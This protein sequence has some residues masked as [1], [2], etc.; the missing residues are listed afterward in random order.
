MGERP[1]TS[2]ADPESRRAY[3]R[4]HYAQNADAYKA[5]AREK[6][7][8]TRAEVRA[9]VEQYLSD[10]SCIDCGE[11][12]RIVLE[13]DH[14]ERATKRFNIGDAVR[15]GYSLRSVRAEVEKCDIR[16]ANCHRRKTWRENNMAG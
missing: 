1:R 13:F 14:R 5:R 10:R 16:C 11:A 3:T 12:D 4:W 6:T 2:R 7:L 15:L 9:F 8:Q